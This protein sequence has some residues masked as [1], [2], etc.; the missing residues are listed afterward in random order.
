MK[1]ERL[2]IRIQKNNADGTRL[3]DLVVAVAGLV[4]ATNPALAT[5]LATSPR[6]TLD[7]NVRVVEGA[8][9]MNG[10][11]VT[12]EVVLARERSST[13]WMRACMR[14]GPVRVM[15]LLVGLE[16][17]GPSESWKQIN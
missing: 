17:K 13:R 2:D 14:L 10:G 12:T 6:P 5:L 4:L 11:H 16:I 9:P 8:I 1:E 15:C 7:T 3:S